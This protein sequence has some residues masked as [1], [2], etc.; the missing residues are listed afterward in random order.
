M[1]GI[2]TR[3]RIALLKRL[4][5][6]GETATAIAAQLRMSRS[7]VLGKVFRLRLRP[8][9][10]ATA[11]SARSG[12]AILR[13]RHKSRPP[14]K[15]RTKPAARPARHESISLLRRA[16]RGFGRRPAIL[17][18]PRAARLCRP[19]QDCG[20]GSACRRG[21]SCNHIALHRAVWR[22]AVCLQPREET[23][24][25]TKPVGGGRNRGASD[26]ADAAVP[27]AE[28]AAAAA[29]A[30]L[31]G[32]R[33]GILGAIGRS[34]LSLLTRCACPTAGR[35]LRFGTHGGRTPSRC[36]CR[37]AHIS[38]HAAY[39]YTAPIQRPR[40][41]WRTH[42]AHSNRGASTVTGRDRRRTRT[43][44]PAHRHDDNA[45]ALRE[46]PQTRPA[47]R[48]GGDDPRPWRRSNCRGENRDPPGRICRRRWAGWVVEAAEMG[49][50]LCCRIFS[51]WS[52]GP[53]CAYIHGEDMR[54]RQVLAQITTS[55]VADWPLACKILA[56]SSS[57]RN[58]LLIKQVTPA[59]LA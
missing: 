7:A 16:G 18:A 10:K 2:W 13:R 56:W 49:G 39:L 9:K 3:E 12:T 59:F 1:R 58:G 42:G 6:D 57:A 32:E 40:P 5:T 26:G 41:W 27:L 23:I 15:H 44:R 52:H 11:A 17:R 51:A 14:I 45:A 43:A 34:T 38:T 31:R 29:D 8:A 50:G 24:L 53:R 20:N 46:R 37:R 47:R 30:E 25:S 55:A 22:E 35:F 36:R 54:C 48:V 28:R 19:P 33:A 4:W 21:G